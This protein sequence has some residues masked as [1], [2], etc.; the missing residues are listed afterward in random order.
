MRT[1]EIYG[2]GRGGA[3]S[4]FRS[5]YGA[6]VREGVMRCCSGVPDD[7]WCKNECHFLMADGTEHIDEEGFFPV[8]GIDC[9]VQ[10]LSWGGDDVENSTLQTYCKECAGTAH[11]FRLEQEQKQEVEFEQRMEAG[12]YRDAEKRQKQRALFDYWSNLTDIAFER[13]C[14]ELFRDL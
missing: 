3:E 8:F 2:D 5:H 1:F 9:H 12:R 14:A 13:E 10:V 4:T 6:D 7:D 11:R